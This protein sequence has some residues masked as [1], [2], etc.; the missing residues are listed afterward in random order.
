MRYRGGHIRR[1]LLVTLGLAA[2]ALLATAS[3]ASADQ[4]Q[5]STVL[6]KTDGF[7]ESFFGG[8]DFFVPPGPLTCHETHVQVFKEGVSG[9]PTGVSPPKTPWAIFVEDYDV[10]FTSGGPDAVP[11]FT[12]YRSGFVLDPAVTFDQPH[13]SYLTASAVVPMS[14]GTTFDFNGGWS[15][16]SDRMLFGNDG[17]AL[18]GF[19]LIHHYVD[20]CTTINSQGHQKYVFARMTGTLN[21][22]PVGSYPDLV[23]LDFIAYNHF[24]LINVTHG[25]C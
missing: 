25:G 10:T 11:T 13:L 24:V 19:D 3:I 14:D 8:C 7:A 6:F 18:G 23:G 17:P 12:N 20:R 15:S 2:A 9:T 1:S 16:I 22:T 4:G 5:A 21:G